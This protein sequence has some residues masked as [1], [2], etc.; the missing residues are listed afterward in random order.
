MRLRITG[1]PSGC[2][3]GVRVDDL[4]VGVVYDIGTTLGCYLLAQGVAEPADEDT[5]PHLPP[6]SEIRFSIGS[7][8][9]P[10]DSTADSAG[11]ERSKAA[12]RPPRRMRD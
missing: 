8:E 7:F 1:Q 9:P 2:I 5:A 6:W 11:D 4:I 12:D 3:D 10:A